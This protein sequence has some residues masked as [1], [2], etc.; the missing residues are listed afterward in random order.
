MI[1]S[2]FI[3]RYNIIRCFS[4]GDSDRET[5]RKIHYQDKNI[6]Q[7]SLGPNQYTDQVCTVFLNR[8]CV[9]NSV[10]SLRTH[11]IIEVVRYSWTSFAFYIELWSN[12][13]YENEMHWVDQRSAKQSRAKQRKPVKHIECILQLIE[14]F[15]GFALNIRVLDTLI[16]VSVTQNAM[17]VLLCA[18]TVRWPD[19]VCCNW[20]Q[21][22]EDVILEDRFSFASLNL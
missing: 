9:I 13:Y 14:R 3:D 22:S 1:D 17:H 4:F 8:K 12:H 7:I 21:N 20:I 6:S 19:N 16:R 18:K 5:K 15:S 10:H 11:L 2:L